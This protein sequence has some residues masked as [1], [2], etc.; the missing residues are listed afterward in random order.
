MHEKFVFIDEDVVY[1]GSLNPL[2]DIGTTE[3]VERVKSK[4]FVEKIW[5]FMNIGTTV[6][7]PK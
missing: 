4:Q 3:A 6:E 2:S 1:R 5:Q 7:A